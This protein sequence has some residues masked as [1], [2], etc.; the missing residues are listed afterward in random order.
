MTMM[1]KIILCAVTYG[2]CALSL[3][4]LSLRLTGIVAWP[5]WWVCAPMLIW[6]VVVLGLLLVAL[7][8]PE[9]FAALHNRIAGWVAGGIAGGIEE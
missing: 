6:P 1:D 3:A 4:F 7:F 9:G 5:W 8:A 2:P